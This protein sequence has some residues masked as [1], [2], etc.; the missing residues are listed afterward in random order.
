MAKRERRLVNARPAARD[1]AVSA[2]LTIVSTPKP[3]VGQAGIAQ[4]N[5]ITSWTL[6]RPR[7]EI[8][9]FGNEYGTSGVCEELGLLH[10]PNPVCNEFGT[11]LLN[12]LFDE[13]RSLGTH[14]LLCF[15]NS[16]IILTGDFLPAIRRLG[17]WRDKWVMVGGRMDI[18]ISAPIDFGRDEW[19]RDIRRTA[20]ETGCPMHISSDYFVF[21][22]ELFRNTPPFAIG[23]PG[24]DNWLLWMALHSGI[25]LVDVTTEVLAIH[26]N[27]APRPTASH[28][29]ITL[30]SERN[31]ALAGAWP[32]SYVLADAS[33]YLEKDRIQRRFRAALTNRMLMLK[34]L[35][36]ARVRRHVRRLMVSPP[37]ASR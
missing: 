30:E 29:P 28:V 8:V 12:G 17:A 35:A 21:P 6:L 24:Y 34:R 15:V 19:E 22:R 18:D 5:A 7:P 10:V 3:F 13:A 1:I 16:D 26:Q 31:R 36:E 33:H 9:L 25:P 27:H 20:Q 14:G 2:S 23:R 11:P 32:C 4:R 37:S